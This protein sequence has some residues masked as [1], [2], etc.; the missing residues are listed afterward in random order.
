MKQKTARRLYW[1]IFILFLI[2]LGSIYYATQKIKE[3]HQYMQSFKDLSSLTAVDPS[4]PT[5]LYADFMLYVD[6][7]EVVFEDKSL[8]NRNPYVLL[9][10]GEESRNL[11]VVRAQGVTVQQFFRSIGIGLTRNCLSM[12]GSDFCSDP[13]TGSTLKFYVN[14]AP[15]ADAQDYV[16][17]DKDKILVSYGS[18]SYRG[19]QTQLGTI[20]D[21]AATAGAPLAMV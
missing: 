5:Q 15:M 12:L 14:G 17:Q 19:I 8:F 3:S 7:K 13:G 16:I 10:P 21:R 1:T 4:K 11:I 9:R 2:A 20:G 6:G 18:E